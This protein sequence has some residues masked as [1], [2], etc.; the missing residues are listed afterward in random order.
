M[1]LE[2]AFAMIDQALASLMLKRADHAAL[3]EALKVVKEAT[4]K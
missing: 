4:N 1:T 3:L 2:Q